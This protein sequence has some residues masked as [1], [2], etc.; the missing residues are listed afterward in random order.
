[1]RVFLHMT[2]KGHDD[3]VTLLDGRG[4]RLQRLALSQLTAWIVQNPDDMVASR[5][6]SLVNIPNAVA[7]PLPRLRDQGQRTIVLSGVVCPRKGQLEALRLFAALPESVRVGLRLRLAGSYSHD[8]YEYD[9]HYVARCQTLAAT[10]PQ[11]TLLGH[12]TKGELTEEL[13]QAH[14][15]FAISAVEGLSNAY[16]ECLSQGLLPIVYEHRHDPLFD[17]LGLTAALI[18]IPADDLKAGAKTLATALAQAPWSEPLARDL[19]VRVAAAFG[20]EHIAD[21]L[22]ALYRDPGSPL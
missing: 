10:M 16:L 1:M 22:L 2:Q 17:T 8:Y 3:P 11:T 13:R 4:S 14:Y 12:L 5:R 18:R 6:P 21:R 20:L 19:Q 9:N 7:P 15:F